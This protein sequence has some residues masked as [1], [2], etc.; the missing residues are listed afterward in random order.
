MWMWKCRQYVANLREALFSQHGHRARTKIKACLCRIEQNREKNPRGFLKVTTT[1]DEVEQKRSS[2]WS[3]LSFDTATVAHNDPLTFS[4]CFSSPPNS[5]RCCHVFQTKEWFSFLKF[6][7]E[8]FGTETDKVRTGTE[9]GC[10][11]K[12]PYT[13]IDKMQNYFSL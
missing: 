5:W 13:C 8:C 7:S 1:M 4:P 9:F 11:P 2:W 12:P 10:S 6:I 3:Q